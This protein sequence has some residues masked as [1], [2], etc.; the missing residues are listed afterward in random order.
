MNRHLK[1]EVANSITHGLA[2][3]ASVVGLVLLVV[4][5][6]QRGTVWHIVSFSIYGT[7]MVLLF[8]ASTL[9]HSF[10]N[11]R[12]K[13]VLH[14]VDHSA[15]FLLIAGTY[16]PVTLTA[17]RGPWGWSLFGCVW[18]LTVVG[19]ALK[20]FYTGRFKVLSTVIY[21]VMGWLMLVA[22]RPMI[23]EIPPAGIRWIVAGGLAYSFGVIF[24]AMKKLP[25]SH[26][27][28]HVFVFMGS[29]CH[30]VAIMFYLY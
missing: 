8:T 6:W 2:A 17:M 7:T 4:F 5:A 9:Y 23:R 13:Q 10:Q 15:I 14:V 20:I 3:V 30:Y 26:A 16:T 25:Y 11:P 29:L 12:I 21:L 1:Q 19:I 18:G 28:W 27:I 22:V 24:Y